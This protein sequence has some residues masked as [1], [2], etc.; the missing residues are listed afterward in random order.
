MYRDLNDYELL[1]M[2][3]ENNDNDFNIL[4]AK[5]KPL[6]YKIVK[7]YE[8][9]FKKYGYE[10]DDLVQIGYITLYKSSMLYSALDETMFYTYF[11]ESLKKNIYSIMKTNNT[12]KKQ[13]LNNALSYDIELKNGI[14]YLD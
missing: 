2:V 7:K 8:S 5:Y 10:L 9:M 12:N 11:N 14:K 3:C 6:I 4:L 1:Y 13:V